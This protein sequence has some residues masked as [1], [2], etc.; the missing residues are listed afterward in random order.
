MCNKTD[1]NFHAHGTELKYRRPGSTTDI[2]HKRQQEKAWVVCAAEK[3]F[4]GQTYHVAKLTKWPN[5]PS[6][7]TYQVAKL[8]KNMR[9]RWL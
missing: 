7:Q 1:E 4:S 9:N 8:T 3:A 5:L 6:G 2:K